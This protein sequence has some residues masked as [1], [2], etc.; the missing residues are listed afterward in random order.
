MLPYSWFLNLEQ[1]DNKQKLRAAANMRKMGFLDDGVSVTNPD[2]LPVG[3]A[4]DPHPT[5]GD[6]LGL[7][8]AACHTGQIRYNDV[9][10]RIDGG[11]SLGDLEQLQN[12]IHASL[13]ATLADSGKFKRF[14]DA[15]LGFSAS[16]DARNELR[17]K[18]VTVRDWWTARIA[19]SKGL[20]PHGPSR[21]DAFTIIGNEVVCAL[22]Q[23]PRNC[24][25][26]IAPTQFPHLWGTPDFEWVQYNSSVHSPIGRNVGQVTGVFAEASFDNFPVA[27]LR[28]NST[29]NLPNLH[30]L[31]EWLKTL[32]AP[33]WD[34]RYLPA[35]DDTLAAQGETLYATNCASCHPLVAPRSAPNAFGKTFAQMNFSTPTFNPATGQS[36]GLGTDKTAA[37]KFATRRAYPGPFEAA[38]LANGLIGPDGK[39]S[40]AAL[41]S[42]S[43]SMII[44]RFFVSSGF[45]I[46]GP[47]VY[48]YLGYRE[49]RSP[50]TAQLIT[51]KARPLDGIAFT[52]PYLHNGSVPTIYDLL[53]PAAQRPAQ[54]YVGS[55]EFDAVKLGYSTAFEDENTILLDTTQIGNG[56][57]GHEYGTSLSES[58]RLAL[59]EYIKTL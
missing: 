39:A 21:T 50:T 42:I 55:K 33:S 54:F 12:A 2:G 29:A 11:Q 23:D 30:A 9:D 14:S 51:Y 6:S 36:V 59:I 45:A 24:E 22:F 57:A 26:G 8:C 56:N 4:K 31:E 13:D 46:P 28:L 37:L 38:A 5:R 53:L 34:E 20:S 1:W 16:A 19:R 52:A 10:I 44:N 7:T 27:S 15:E 32:Q 48:N 25:P 47:E 17:A 43:G 49:S 58:D 41:L 35:I 18:M 3:F 40:V